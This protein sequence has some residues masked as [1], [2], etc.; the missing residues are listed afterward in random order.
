MSEQRPEGRAEG[1][2][3]GVTAWQRLARMARPRATRANAFAAL[4]AIGLGF[5]IATQVQQ[6]NNS[7]LDELREDELVRILDD[8]SQEQDRLTSNIARAIRSVPAAIRERQ[9][10]LFAK[11]DARY[12]A[13]VARKLGGK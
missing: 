12:G 8:V 5:A 2:V 3:E 13:E 4:L 10:A 11:A 1:S 9:L 7:G 6:T